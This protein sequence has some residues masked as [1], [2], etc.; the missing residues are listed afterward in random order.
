MRLVLMTKGQI[1]TTLIMSKNNSQKGYRKAAYLL[2]KCL[3][4]QQRNSPN[5]QNNIDL[6][7]MPGSV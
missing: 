4:E 3:R 1:S 2:L 6:K 5:A 7:N